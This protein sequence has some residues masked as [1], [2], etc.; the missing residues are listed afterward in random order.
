MN[1]SKTLLKHLLPS[2]SPAEKAFQKPHPP[3]Y[4]LTQTSACS[5]RISMC[6][7]K[8]IQVNMAPVPHISPAGAWKRH[9]SLLHTGNT[10]LVMSYT[11][12]YMLLPSRL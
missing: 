4:I 1:H 5:E 7:K 2:D 3:N 9:F 11:P 10:H 8:R 12:D 6:A